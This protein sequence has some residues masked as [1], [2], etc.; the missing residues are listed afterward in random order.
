MT[1]PENQVSLGGMCIAKE[2]I[3]NNIICSNHGFCHNDSKSCS[4]DPTFTGLHCDA[5]AIGMIPVNNSKQCANVKCIENDKICNGNG[6]CGGINFDQCVCKPGFSGKLCQCGPDHLPHPSSQECVI[7]LC[8]SPNQLCYGRSECVLVEKL[9][10]KEFICNG[11]GE[12]TDNDPRQGCAQCLPG[13]G[14]LPP[15]ADR[16]CLSTNC[17][18]GN[19]ICNGKGQC[20]SYGFC[21]CNGNFS[22][23][24]NCRGCKQTF[25]LH[26]GE[27]IPDLCKTGNTECNGRGKCDMNRLECRCEPGF[28]GRSCELCAQGLVFANSKTE[29]AK[30][31]CV[32]DDKVCGGRGTCEGLSFTWC[33]CQNRSSG[34]FC[35]CDDGYTQINAA[36]LT[37]GRDLCKTQR[38]RCFGR[39]ACALENAQFVC[40]DCGNFPFNDP[41]QQCQG[42]LPGAAYFGNAS[43]YDCRPAKCITGSSI[44]SG[45]GTCEGSG[46]CRCGDPALDPVHGCSQCLASFERVGDT[47]VP[48]GCVHSGTE[49][50][51]RG[52]CE[53][54]VCTCSTYLLDAGAKCSVCADEHA[55]VNEL[56]TVCRP[57]FVF[58]RD[59]CVDTR[60]E[61]GQTF[62][63]VLFQCVDGQLHQ[64]GV[65]MGLIAGIVVL[66]FVAVGLVGLIAFFYLKRRAWLPGR[67]AVVTTRQAEVPRPTPTDT[68]A[69]VRETLQYDK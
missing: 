22:S 24:S 50:A 58:V 46:E 63:T 43:N 12:F 38:G 1:C 29:C 23:F 9:G 49:C 19:T 11:C 64:D 27:C 8:K 5:C 68:E 34:K 66:V 48:S 51:G 40:K 44:C 13:K 15:P 35:E 20:Q 26:D 2:C 55:L 39:G 33:N 59:R 69:L 17:I 56:C 7:N 25:Q 18:T 52:R 37:C 65:S 60:C 45:Q 6:S 54:G 3:F 67:S 21:V 47:C 61:P 41:K 57:G 42:C 30:P 14:F 31:A 32:N 4:C 53:A 16:K 28:S 10:Q 62:N 36:L